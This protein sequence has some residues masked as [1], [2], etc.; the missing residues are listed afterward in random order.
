MYKLT[1]RI[2][3]K[4]ITWIFR[5]QWDFYL[6]TKL[7]LPQTGIAYEL[8]EAEPDFIVSVY[9]EFNIRDNEFPCRELMFKVSAEC[10]ERYCKLPRCYQFV[11]NPKPEDDLSWTRYSWAFTQWT[12]PRSRAKTKKISIVD[13]GKWQH[14]VDK[15]NEI[16]NKVGGSIDVYG[17]L[18]GNPLK[19]YHDM[20]AN[21]KYRGIEQYA[22]YLSIEHT[23]ADDYLT[24]KLTDAVL[25]EAIPIYIGAPNVGLYMLEGSYIDEKDVN[26]IDWDNWQSE[27]NRRQA[28]IKKQKALFLKKFNVFSYFNLLTDDL[29]LLDKTRP[30]VLDS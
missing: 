10:G 19:G 16:G 3:N 6:Y 26:A 25:C 9:Q 8:I 23:R 11:N 15:I 4:I 27:Y 2:S 1:T 12:G 22:F 24:E 13:S 18:G 20:E 17:G 7:I 21:E 29:G 30:I 28:I 14:R 5:Y